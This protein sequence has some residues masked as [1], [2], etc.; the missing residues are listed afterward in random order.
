MGSEKAKVLVLSDLHYEHGYHKGVYEGEAHD[1]LAKL[2]RRHKPDYT[3]S[4]GDW[5]RAWTP[6][7]FDALV[8]KTEL[9]TVLGNHDAAST[10]SSLTNPSGEKVL[11]RDAEVKE[12]SNVRF[13]F[14]HG[15]VGKEP[16]SVQFKDTDSYLQKCRELRG[17]VDVLLTHITPMRSDFSAPMFASSANLKMGAQAMAI[18]N[19]KVS[20]S[21]H[22]HPRQFPRGEKVHNAMNFLVDSSQKNRVYATMELPGLNV[23]LWKDRCIIETQRLELKELVRR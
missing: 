4:L 22:E 18:V 3:V 8:W 9:Y 11:A 20:F 6:K 1:W 17:R 19:P 23:Q 21:G 13:G 5:G 7:D 10:F 15:V 2:I 12:I 16:D 14:I